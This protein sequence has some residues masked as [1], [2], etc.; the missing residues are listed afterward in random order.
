MSNSVGTIGA[1]PPSVS[2]SRE[3]KT[4]DGSIL[5]VVLAEFRRGSAAAHRYERLRYGS[6][7]D[8]GITAT[9]IPRRIFE[10]FYSK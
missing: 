4:G 5:G 3:T 8:A 10:E 7:R 9:D 2:G 1:G 6:A